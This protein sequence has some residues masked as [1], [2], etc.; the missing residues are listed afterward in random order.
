[1]NKYYFNRKFDKMSTLM[2]NL[3][4]LGEEAAFNEANQYVDNLKSRISYVDKVDTRNQSWMA[5]V[6]ELMESIGFFLI[7]SGKYGAVFKKEGYPWA[8]KIFMR[9]TAYLTWLKFC[10]ANPNNIHLPK[11]KGKVTK[12]NDMFMAVR[13][14]MLRQPLNIGEARELSR[15][16]RICE[17]SHLDNITDDELDIQMFLYQHRNIADVHGENI[18]I[19][20]SGVPVVFD[21]LYNWYNPIDKKFAMD[22]DSLSDFKELF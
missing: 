4:N 2:R 9:D 8:V 12:I 10:K 18:M 16:Q 14:E 7:G 22:T 1:M 13:V 15:L 21:A 19:N 6:A 5:T 17:G 11:F 3:I 20:S